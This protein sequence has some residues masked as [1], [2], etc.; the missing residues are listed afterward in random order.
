MDM[1]EVLATYIFIQILGY[2]VYPILS[3]LMPQS[4]D[5][6]LGV[7]KVFGMLFVTAFFWVTGSYSLTAFLAVTLGLLASSAL[8][9]LD[10]RTLL[11]NP[12]IKTIELLFLGSFI[13][14]LVLRGFM[15][16]IYWGE[17]P[18]DFTFL[19]YFIRSDSIPPIDPWASGNQLQY[20]YFGYLFWGALYK[21]P[22]LDSGYGY[23]VALAA[24]GAVYLV[25]LYSLTLW[26]TKTKLGAV[27]GSILIS[28]ISNA[29]MLYLVLLKGKSLNFDTW[30][31]SSRSLTFPSFN[32][33]PIWSLIFGDLHAHV[34]AFPFVVLLVQLGIYLSKFKNFAVAVLLG[35][36][37]GFHFGFNAWDLFVIGFLG[38]VL[39][40]TSKKPW[41]YRFVDLA[42]LTVSFFYVQH[43][44]SSEITPSKNKI[45]WGFVYSNEFN[46][47]WDVFSHFGIFIVLCG[48]IVALY[49]LSS[50]KISDAIKACGFFV[51]LFVPL[52]FTPEKAWGVTIPF[53]LLGAI[54]ATALTRKRLKNP[55]IFQLILACSI[56]LVYIEHIFIL[57]RM[58][59]LFKTYHGV[60]LI[61]GLASVG[62]L[63]LFFELKKWFLAIPIV[64]LLWGFVGTMLSLYI[65][66]NFS[67]VPGPRPTLNGRAYLKEVDGDESKLISWINRNIPGTPTIVEAVGRS[68]GE[69]SRI[70]MHTGIPIVL[71]WDH[72]VTQ[73]GTERSEVESRRQDVK[74]IYTSNS[75]DEISE[76]LKKYGVKYLVWGN[77][78]R[79]TYGERS[80][81]F[82]NPRRFKPV[83]NS[84]PVYL[85]EVIWE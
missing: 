7:S 70:A 1:L 25:S 83:F 74:T 60:W 80:I 62:A 12:N 18:M 2:S 27:A 66:T 56:F 38:L 29:Q 6:G 77:L 68:Y 72:H 59:T 61:F 10:D 48:S 49:A 75:V 65:M 64:S 30:W 67:R 20:Y 42:L 50:F 19:N 76:L 47:F 37:L 44:V 31:A 32:E 63:S 53:S 4:Q 28:T 9:Y 23:N 35:S 8:F 85:F 71:G 15:P 22:A 14:F 34:I 58:N 82:D 26:V 5:R 17:K 24:T 57:D 51:L 39:G 43:L 13:G 41:K 69:Y 78:E 16:E 3:L 79:K 54:S 46:S 36:A 55:L 81:F 73:R 52:L 11:R 40:I 33:Y 84:G 21:L 45:H